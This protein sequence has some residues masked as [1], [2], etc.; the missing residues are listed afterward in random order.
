MQGS[1]I[2][3]S[4]VSDVSL[5][6]SEPRRQSPNVKTAKSAIAASRTG[7]RSST[8]TISVPHTEPVPTAFKDPEFE[9]SGQKSNYLFGGFEENQDTSQLLSVYNRR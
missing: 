9:N 4:V 8:V 5:L 1:G 6:E 3:V 2:A 7:R